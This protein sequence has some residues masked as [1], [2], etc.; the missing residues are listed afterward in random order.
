MNTDLLDEYCDENFGH[1]DWQI[2]EDKHGN[3]IVTFYVV[4]R[5]GY[6]EESDDE[7]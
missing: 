5:E 6:V 2:D 3:L 7:N 4:P 1:T